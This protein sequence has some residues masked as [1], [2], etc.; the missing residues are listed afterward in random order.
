M[1]VLSQLKGRQIEKVGLVT[2][3]EEENG[4]G[5]KDSLTWKVTKVC[6]QQF[7]L[8]YSLTYGHSYFAKQQEEPVMG[9][10]ENLD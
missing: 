8:S 4:L 10:S 1:F 7:N 3:A 6:S 2:L 9:F 5:I